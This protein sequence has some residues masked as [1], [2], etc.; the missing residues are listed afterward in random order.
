MEPEPTFETYRA[1]VPE[2][3]RAAL[4]KLRETIRNLAPNAVES[5]SYAVPTFKYLG[6]P[7]IYFGAAKKHLAIYGMPGGTIRF[8]PNDP[9]AD[10]FVEGLVRARMAE[11]EAVLAR[12]RRRRAEHA[13]A[14]AAAEA[15]ETQ[16]GA[17]QA[18]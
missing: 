9:P 6:R 10:A 16:E 18:R 15:T 5:I 2:E 11:I 7:L 17:E 4:S 14:A 3:H 8:E 13:S 1:S 12:R